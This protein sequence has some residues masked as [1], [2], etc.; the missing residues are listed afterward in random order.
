MLVKAAVLSILTSWDFVDDGF[1]DL[2]ARHSVDV[3]AHTV[4]KNEYNDL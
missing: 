1:L 3:L 2:L 4:N